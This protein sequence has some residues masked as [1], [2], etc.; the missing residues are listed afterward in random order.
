MKARA[1]RFL[2]ACKKNILV[3]YLRTPI[4]IFR[5]FLHRLKDRKYQP[6]FFP[7]KAGEALP[8]V[9][10]LK[11]TGV[12]L[13]PGYIQP[14]PLAELTIAFEEAICKSPIGRYSPD[15]LHAEEIFL[16]N[17]RF[18]EIALDSYLLEIIGQYFGRRFGLAR[19]A[20]TRLLPTPPIRHSSYRWHHDARGRQLHIMVLLNEV[21]SGGQHMT[22]LKGSHNRYYSY[23]RGVINTCF[24]SD[25][26]KIQLGRNS[27]TEV[28][29]RPGTVAIF[30]SNGLHSGNRNLLGVRDSLLFCY[31]TRKHFKP[32]GY[33]SKDLSFIPEQKLDVIKFNPNYQIFD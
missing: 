6:N 28:T 21:S 26:S 10:E 22:Y 15:S 33:R 8:L 1:H 12:I 16:E 7:D 2:K 11:R 17:A 13:L 30:D 3:A 5:E 20:A 25:I 29:G 27:I 4:Y 24:D 31:V 14:D 23:R 9:D 19:S 32:V 18:L